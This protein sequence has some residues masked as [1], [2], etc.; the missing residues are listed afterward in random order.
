MYMSTVKA[1]FYT[2][3]KYTVYTVYMDDF[4]LEMQHCAESESKC[5]PGYW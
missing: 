4:C 1:G 3:S 2:Y 5:V